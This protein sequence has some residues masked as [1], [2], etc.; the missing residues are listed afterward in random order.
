[1]TV[2]ETESTEPF[3]LFEH[4]ELAVDEHRFQADLAWRRTAYWLALNVAMLAGGLALL[5]TPDRVPREL[6]AVLFALGAVASIVAIV[7][8]LRNRRDE[9]E[10][11]AEVMRLGEALEL[12]VQQSIAGR[13]RRALLVMLGALAVANIAGC[14]HTVGK[15]LEDPAAGPG[16]LSVRVTLVDRPTA[17]RVLPV[18][19][20][21]GAKLVTTLNLR[22][23]QPGIA[24]LEPGTYVIRVPLPRPC[25]RVVPVP[26]R[27]LATVELR[28]RAT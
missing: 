4:F 1:M 9:R 8:A 2:T 22:T 14:V 15:A 13:G 17:Q 21:R 27:P 28:C 6:I 24:S 3:G 19:I 11:R 16:A 5:A 18:A 23:A 12:P 20:S 10:A 25:A 7:S 26:R